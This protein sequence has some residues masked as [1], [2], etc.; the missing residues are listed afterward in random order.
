MINDDVRRALPDKVRD[1]VLTAGEAMG[2]LREMQAEE[3]ATYEKKQ[4]ERV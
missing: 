4:I 2:V 3:W 1:G